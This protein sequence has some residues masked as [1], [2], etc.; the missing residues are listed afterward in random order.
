L[1]F[2]YVSRSLGPAGRLAVA[3]AALE[4]RKTMRVPKNQPFR[5]R[6]RFAIAGIAVALKT[7]HSLRYQAAALAC[8]ILVLAFFRLEPL[9]WAVVALSSAAV[10]SAELFNTAL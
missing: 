1:A 6:I 2:G 7:E 9:W 3:S 4:P 5:I 8:V 10:I